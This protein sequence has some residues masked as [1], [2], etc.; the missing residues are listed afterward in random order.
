MHAQLEWL[1]EAFV[2]YSSGDVELSD[3]GSETS[4]LLDEVS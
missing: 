3:P 1:I 4:S 2:T